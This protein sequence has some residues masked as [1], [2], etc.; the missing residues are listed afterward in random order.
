[1]NIVNIILDLTTWTLTTNQTIAGGDILEYTDDQ[2][3]GGAI[4]R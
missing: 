2:A 4:N 3:Q 1:M